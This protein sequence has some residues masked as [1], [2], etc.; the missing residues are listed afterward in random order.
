VTV[1]AVAV[2]VVVAPAE[3]TT[4]MLDMGQIRDPLGLLFSS[5][6]AAANASDEGG[7]IVTNAMMP[8]QDRLIPALARLGYREVSFQGA[9][10]AFDPN[11]SMVLAVAECI[12]RFSASFL[13]EDEVVLA[14][15][16]ELGG[17]GLDLSSIAYCSDTERRNPSCPLR[18][19]SEIEPIRW[20]KASSLVD[21]KDKL[22]PLVMVFSHP[23]ISNA[24][25]RFWLPIS[26]GC[27]A[28]T[29]YTLA[30][31]TALF[32]VIEREAL[33]VLWLQTL[34]LA[35][36][37]IDIPDDPLAPYWELCLRSPEGIS[38]RFFDATTDLGIPTVYA[39]RKSALTERCNTLVA[40]SSASTMSEAIAKTIVDLHMIRGA[41]KRERKVP[42]SFDSYSN[43]MHG[44]TFMAR[45][46]NASKFNFLGSSGEIRLLSS[47]PSSRDYCLKEVTG[48]LKRRGLAAYLVDLTT[49]EA[50]F[51]GLK[52]VRAIVPEMQPLSFRHAA[53]FLGTPR[54]YRLPE[55]MGYRSY[56]EE[57]LNQYPQPF[58]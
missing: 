51:A 53:R 7:L 46:E 34:P 54:L 27:S 40:C 16:Q 39:L 50:E 1:L 45:A 29:S 36:I 44:A 21:G 23:G 48:I 4:T 57:Q 28:H 22:V 10:V 31:R 42:T 58:A 38:Y 9:G 17:E 33:T 32:E 37:Q 25:E 3:R 18:I 30:A 52:V 2:A 15:A 14:T 20:I 47:Y 55:Q 5:V 24:A 19:A 11:Q 12:E 41:F 8:P 49:R 13:R 35:E 56:S 6:T 43:M 26:T